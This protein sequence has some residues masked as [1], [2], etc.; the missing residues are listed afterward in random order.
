[1]TKQYLEGLN[2][3][4]FFAAFFVL[5]GHC[6]HNLLLLDIKWNHKLA[7]LH[8]GDVAVDFFF[9]LSGFLLSYL[10][11]FEI[12]KYGD[13]DI[14]NFFKRRILR[15]F[16]LYYL[17][18]LLGFLSLGVIYPYLTGETFFSFNPLEGLIYYLVFLP[19][20]VIAYGGESIG[21][22]YSLWS[23]GVEEQFY[24][25]FP[26]LIPL[27]IK[28]KRTIILFMAATLVFYLIYFLFTQTDQIATSS[29]VKSFIATLRFHYMLT[30]GLFAL[31][32]IKNPNKV[33]KLFNHKM[34]RLLIWLGVIIT[35]FTNFF[36]GIDL[37]EAIIFSLIIITVSSKESRIINLEI[38]PLVYLGTISYG[39]YVFHPLVSY[40]I[41]LFMDLLNNFHDL[42]AT[43]PIL[44][45]GLELL[46]TIFV[47]H[48]SFKYYESYFLKKKQ[49]HT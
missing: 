7:V 34:I 2:S 27:I 8:K 21:S 10:A 29:T 14:R 13:L 26:F 46:L 45:Y 5:I 1:V 6:N 20:Y 12:T 44:Y 4:R 42:I 35:F 33:K 25:F 39:I 15:I 31:V 24:L 9:V 3:L 19:N 38:K 23:I 48:I 41:R 49:Y 30:G 36:E 43:F 47:A 32:L 18:V 22:I 28:S 40:V 17:A 16:P 37:L 11:Y